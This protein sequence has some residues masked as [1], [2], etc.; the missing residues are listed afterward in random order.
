[1]PT[2]EYRCKKCETIFEKVMLLGDHA[3]RPLSPCPKCNSKK[4]EHIIGTVQAITGKKT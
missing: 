1:M 4:V 3:R 2:Y